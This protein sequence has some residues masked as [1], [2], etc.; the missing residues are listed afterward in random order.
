MS[1]KRLLVS[2]FC[3]RRVLLH[4]DTNFSH[5]MGPVGYKSAMVTQDHILVV[6]DDAEIRNLLKEYRR[7]RFKNAG[8]SRPEEE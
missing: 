6:D 4:C 2:H 1:R 7:Y 8:Q 5:G 3:S